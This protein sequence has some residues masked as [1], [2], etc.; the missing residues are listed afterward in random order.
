MQLKLAQEGTTLIVLVQAEHLDAGNIRSFR[1]AMMP[2]LEQHPHILLDMSE[3][4]F[5]DSAGVGT[6]IACLRK[7]TE[8]HGDFRLCSLNRPVSMIFDLMRMH[9]LFVVYND[10]S[11]ALRGMAA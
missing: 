5:V 7:A 2:L 3:L 1:D 4:K 6:L 8:R 9:Q 11:E 10:Q